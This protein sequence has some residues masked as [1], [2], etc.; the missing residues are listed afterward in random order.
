V[1]THLIKIAA[2]DLQTLR[3]TLCVGGVVAVAKCTK[4]TLGF[5]RNR[6]SMSWTSAGSIRDR[7]C[8][9]PSLFSPCCLI[10]VFSVVRHFAFL[11]ASPLQL[12][13]VAFMKLYS[14]LG[15]ET[16]KHF[17]SMLQ[18]DSSCLQFS[19]KARCTGSRV[20]PKPLGQYFGG[21]SKF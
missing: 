1:D 14:M 9:E 21:I 5:L 7:Q 3:C 6:S 20:L 4:W 12:I 13:A 15:D 11:D 10:A 8:S 19:S 16:K 17:C 18:L 2:G